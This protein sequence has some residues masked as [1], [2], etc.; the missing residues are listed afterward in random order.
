MSENTI[1]SSDAK[2][3]IDLLSAVERVSIAAKNSRLLEDAFSD[4][5]PHL[6]YLMTKLKIDKM[7]AIMM[8]LFVENSFARKTYL[9]QLAD[10]VGCS[11]LMSLRMMKWTEPLVERELVTMMDNGHERYYFV[12]MDVVD[13]FKND[14]CYKPKILSGLSA[15][16]LFVEMGRLFDLCEDG[17]LTKEALYRKIM[18]LIEANHHLVFCRTIK[19]YDLATNNALLLLLFCVLFVNK[20]DDCVGLHD[21]RFLFDSDD[22]EWAGIKSDL[23]ENRQRLQQLHFIEN[24]NDYGFIDREAYHLS[25]ETKKVLLGELDVP[26]TIKRVNKSDGMIRHGEIKERKL[27]FDDSVSSKFDDLRKL[28]SEESLCG[29]RSRLSES[30]MP[31]GI[32]CLFYGAPGTGKTELAMQLARA[33]G[34]DVFQVDFA[35]L[36]SKWVG[37]S[38]KNVKGLFNTYSELCRES[39]LE[40]IMLFNEADSIIGKR[41]ESAEYAVEKM[42]NTI[43]NIILQEME[44]FEGIMIATSNLIQNF[45]RAFERRFLYK[46]KFPKPEL[47]QRVQIWKINLPD[48]SEDII[49]RLAEDYDFTGGQISNIARHYVIDKVLHADKTDSYDAIKSH[50]DS[51]RFETRDGRRIGFA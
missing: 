50:C 43:Q 22:E 31:V 42:E 51:E 6:A 28:L 16:T 11:K 21:I 25:I 36:K 26:L 40:P 47:E 15:K 13:A 5:E 33:T 4:V 32:T 2:N 30:G 10:Y 41:T 38:E 37:E 44:Q 27:V 20:G 7:A 29:V 14:E 12:N 39:K 49:A 3:E 45:D 1:Y 34:R 18:S 17:L 23:Q 48:L 24:N 8:S 19:G 35:S 46:I 9:T